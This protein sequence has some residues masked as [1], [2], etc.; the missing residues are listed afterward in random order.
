MGNLLKRILTSLILL[1]ITIYT[2]YKGGLVFTSY[3]LLI[4]CL[5]FWEYRKILKVESKL[6]VVLSFFAVILFPLFA[7]HSFDLF[8]Y[9]SLFV[10]LLWLIRIL[11]TKIKIEEFWSSY[12][13]VILYT[14]FG[15][16]FAILIRDLD[17]GLWLMA[18][19][20]IISALNDISAYLIGKF[21]GIRKAFP[22]VSPNKTFEGSFAGIVGSVLSAVVLVRYFQ[23]GLSTLQS[24]FIGLFVSFLGIVGDLFESYIKRKSGVK[25]TGNLLPGHGGILDRVDSLIFILPFFY[26]ISKY[27]II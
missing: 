2:V 16:N 17:N 18:S 10:L 15:I 20:L 12:L 8:L 11:Y 24:M 26:L 19:V 21:F 5:G 13:F 4:T 3:L 23:F 7:H 25:D 1:P 6:H 22:K 9:L 14:G 27:L